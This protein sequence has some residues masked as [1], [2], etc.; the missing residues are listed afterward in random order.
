[1]HTGISGRFPFQSPP[2][3]VTNRQFGRYNLP[4]HHHSSP[5]PWG[6]VPTKCHWKIQQTYDFIVTTLYP[7]LHVFLFVVITTAMKLTAIFT[8]FFV[9]DFLGCRISAALVAQILVGRSWRSTICEFQ[10]NHVTLQS[11]ISHGIH[12]PS[13][14]LTASQFAPEDKPRANH[15]R[16]FPRLPKPSTFQMQT[17]SFREGI[18]TKK[19]TLADGDVYLKL[20]EFFCLENPVAILDLTRPPRMPVAN[21]GLGWDSWS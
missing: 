3:G 20:R 6:C 17:V 4:R 7:S 16:I 10:K 13:P 18:P 15:K 14:K 1:M 21:E 2:F 11:S 12:V 19:L 5:K 9:E 8:V